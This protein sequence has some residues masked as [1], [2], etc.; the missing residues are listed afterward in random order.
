LMRE[1]KKDAC[2]FSFRRE[3]SMCNTT[4]ARLSDQS[5]QSAQKQ[6]RNEVPL[7]GNRYFMHGP[8]RPVCPHSGDGNRQASPGGAIMDLSDLAQF[9]VVSRL[10][11]GQR[12]AF[13]ARCARVAVRLLNSMS[14]PVK[15][16]EMIALEMTVQLLE[17]SATGS[18]NLAQLDL[19]MQKLR[20]LAFTSPTQC[21][22]RSDS[23]ICQVVH[24]AYAAGLTA[25]SGSSVDAQDALKSAFAA[26][27]TAE[28]VEAEESLWGELR[29]V[30]KAGVEAAGT[31]RG[32]TPSIQA[33]AQPVGG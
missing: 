8:N 31:G 28:S 12:V 25:F 1:A 30:Q 11:R 9:M 24:A 20:H 21:K 6:D 19:S 3:I 7:Q 15:L 10:A 22:F 26:A 18:L 17:E 14:L 29:L 13:A 2:R 33:I 16:K 32:T 23:I 27:R 4:P 5:P